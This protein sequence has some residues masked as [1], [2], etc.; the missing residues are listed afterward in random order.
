M[1]Q[2]YSGLTSCQVSG[3][4]FCIRLVPV[5]VLQSEWRERRAQPDMMEAGGE[6]GQRWPPPTSRPQFD[7][8][9]PGSPTSPLSPAQLSE[10]HSEET[11]S[12]PTFLTLSG[13]KL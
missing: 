5:T 13:G 10:P 2:G 4:M 3:G 1:L 8:G 9:D 12:Q 11:R 6:T 7:C